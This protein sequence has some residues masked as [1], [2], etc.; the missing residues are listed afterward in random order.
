MDG[1][2]GFHTL[3]K[4]KADCLYGEVNAN[5]CKEIAVLRNLNA[6]DD[7]LTCERNGVNGIRDDVNALGTEL[8]AEPGDLN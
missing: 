6:L 5:R 7:G 4:R 1:A 3:L 8:N 2:R